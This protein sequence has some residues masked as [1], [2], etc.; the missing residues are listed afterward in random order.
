ML[1]PAF[2]RGEISVSD[3]TGLQPIRLHSE[4]EQL[5]S[6]IAKTVCS[7]RKYVCNCNVRGIPSS[8]HGYLPYQIAV[9]SVTFIM[10]LVRLH[11]AWSGV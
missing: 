6:L 5:F 10:M 11:R 1:P 3:H 9:F 2:R 8:R 4:L 7:R